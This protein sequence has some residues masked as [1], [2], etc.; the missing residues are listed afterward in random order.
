MDTVKHN[1]TFFGISEVSQKLNV[2]QKTIRR[3]I[4]GEK[5]KSIKIGG[6]YRIPVDTL[7]D[8]INKSEIIDEKV[9]GFDLFGKK[10][11]ND[12]KKSNSKDE[13]NWVDVVD[14]WD[15]I[16][17][18]NLTFVDLFSGA[19]GI[20]KGLELAGLNGICGMDWFKEAGQTYRRNFKHP[21]VEGDIKLAEKKKEFYDT[22]KKQLNGKQLN[23]MAGGFP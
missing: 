9:V 3:Y 6:V 7:N 8:F 2:S 10:I 14:N 11:F 20:T 23:I 17:K 16:E 18:S 5:L 19:G 12:I 21:F 13:V 1:N 15:N 22:V 4:A